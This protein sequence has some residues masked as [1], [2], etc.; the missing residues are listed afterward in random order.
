MQLLGRYIERAVLIKQRH[1]QQHKRTLCVLCRTPI[2]KFGKRGSRRHVFGDVSADLHGNMI[3]GIFRLDHT[4]VK[5]VPDADTP[6]QRLSQI[7]ILIAEGHLVRTDRQS[8]QREL[9]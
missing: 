2:R 7:L 4:A 5:P 6:E 8:P 3:V 9:L 1:I